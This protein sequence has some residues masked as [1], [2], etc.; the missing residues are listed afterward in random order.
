MNV[1]YEDGS[2]L[3][4]YPPTNLLPGGVRKFY[5]INDLLVAN[6]QVLMAAQTLVT[7]WPK[8]VALRSW[9]ETVLKSA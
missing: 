5:T 4:I 3:R 9:L 6:L 1:I 2:P 8:D 7:A